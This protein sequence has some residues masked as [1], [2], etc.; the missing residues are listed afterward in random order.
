[1][2]RILRSAFVISVLS[3]LAACSDPPHEVKAPDGS[4]LPQSGYTWVDDSDHGQGVKWT[5]GFVST[6]PPHIVADEKEGSWSPDDGYAWVAKDDANDFRVTWTPGLPH[7]VL[8][9]V[10]AAQQEGYWSTEPGYA[11]SDPNKLS[12]AVW[13]A[14]MRHPSYGHIVSAPGENTWSPVA[15]YTF[16]R[17]D[18]ISS[19]VWTPQTPNPQYPHVVASDT[20]D[21]WRPEAG[22]QFASNAP[23]DFS[24][25]PIDTSSSDTATESD[26]DKVLGF[27][28]KL[29]AA[30]VA[31]EV[32]QPQDGDGFFTRN[33]VRP[34]AANIRDA[35]AKSAADDLK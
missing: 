33:V 28:L 20:P 3:V 25:V 17:N 8:K 30:V 2:L 21:S 24:V 32:A 15:G 7:S 5:P 34:A 35:A 26:G 13:T 23:D 6:D 9:H 10:L 11:F 19:A 12:E 18:D 16:S 29:G 27:F 31:D 4:W 1:V 14:G 22:Y